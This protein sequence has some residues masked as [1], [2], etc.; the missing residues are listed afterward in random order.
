MCC[1]KVC[2][3]SATTASGTQLGASTLNEP[4]SCSCS[5]V[6]QHRHQLQDPPRRTAQMIG[7]LVTRDPTSPESARAVSRAVSFA[8]LAFIP[9]RQAD[10]DPYCFV[11]KLNHSFQRASVMP[12]L[13]FVTVHQTTPCRPGLSKTRLELPHHIPRWRPSIRRYC[14]FRP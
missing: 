12:R 8:S 3:K 6:P 10:H 1:R 11:A 4:A 9:N 2:T 5:T 14:S 13:L 7:Q